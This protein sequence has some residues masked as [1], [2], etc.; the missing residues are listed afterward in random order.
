[1]T[2]VV[3]EPVEKDLGSNVRAASTGTR[4]ANEDYATDM[5]H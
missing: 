3:H 2:E 5:E 4:T 1:M